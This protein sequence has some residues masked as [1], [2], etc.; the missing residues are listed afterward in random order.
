MLD[1][2]DLAY[3]YNYFDFTILSKLESVGLQTQQYLHHSLLVS[4]DHAAV[5]SQRILGFLTDVHKGCK[6]VCFVVFSLP[7]L[8][9]YH[10]S[11][12]L[13][14]VK[15]FHIRSEFALLDLGKVKHILHH[16]LKAE[17]T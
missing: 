10:V 16:E 3:L 13:H 7:L 17:R 14:N 9:D 6:K 2:M 11:H 8:Y 5:A 15:L 4:L 12:C 1:V